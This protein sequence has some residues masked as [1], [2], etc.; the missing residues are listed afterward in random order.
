MS[1]CRKIDL[2]HRCRIVQRHRIRRQNFQRHQ[3]VRFRIDNRLNLGAIH[4]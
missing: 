2:D 1:E 4:A 3:F